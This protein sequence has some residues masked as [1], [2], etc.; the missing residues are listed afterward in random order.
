VK[1]SPQHVGQSRLCAA[2]RKSPARGG[3]S[4][5][6]ECHIH[7]E[8]WSPHASAPGRRRL[9]SDGVGSVCPLQLPFLDPWRDEIADRARTQDSGPPVV[10]RASASTILPMLPQ[11][12][13]GGLYGS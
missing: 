11:R 12:T 2:Q 3:A 8:T 1:D 6:V 7:G 9:P 5:Q 4:H 10:Q 13:S